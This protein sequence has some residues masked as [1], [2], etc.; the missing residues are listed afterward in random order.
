MY[1]QTTLAYLY[2]FLL[3]SFLKTGQCVER[4]GTL[5]LYIPTLVNVLRGG[6]PSCFTF[7]LNIESCR[8]FVLQLH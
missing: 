5:L 8:R 4:W 1:K 3:V 2:Y 6:V 7:H